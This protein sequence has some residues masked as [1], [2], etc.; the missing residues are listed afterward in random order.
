MAEVAEGVVWQSRE[1]VEAK[2]GDRFWGTIRSELVYQKEGELL[3]EQEVSCFSGEV[4][5]GDA[6]AWTMLS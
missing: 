6:A 2:V 1:N 5:L 3:V 4:G